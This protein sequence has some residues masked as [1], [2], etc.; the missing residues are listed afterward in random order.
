[1]LANSSARKFFYICL[2]VFILTIMFSPSVLDTTNYGTHFGRAAPDLPPVIA[3]EVWESGATV[4]I[5]R[6]KGRERFLE[7][8][9]L[10]IIERT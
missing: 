9:N 10:I 7:K 4:G 3:D 1:M 5:L 2:A 6:F 8:C